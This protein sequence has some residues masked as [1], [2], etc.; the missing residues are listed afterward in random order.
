M[1]LKRFSINVKK[2][3]KRDD[4]TERLKFG[5]GTITMCLFLH[6]NDFCIMIFLSDIAFSM[7]FFD[8]H[9][10]NQIPGDS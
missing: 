4:Q 5:A 9:Q 1:F 3:I 7:S 2:K 10:N 6:E 8:D